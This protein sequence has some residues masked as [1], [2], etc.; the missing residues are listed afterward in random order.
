MRVDCEEADAGRVDA[1][2]DEVRADVALI[3]EE[4]L[5]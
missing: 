2:D 1:R 4:V 5:F 3:A